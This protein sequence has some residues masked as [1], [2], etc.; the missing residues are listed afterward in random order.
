VNRQL[1]NLTITALDICHRAGKF[2][3]ATLSNLI[4]NYILGHFGSGG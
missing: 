2:G 4:D 3:K 1:L